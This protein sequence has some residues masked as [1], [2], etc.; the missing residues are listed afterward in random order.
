MYAVNMANLTDGSEIG[1]LV[2][3]PDAGFDRIAGLAGRLL[4]MPLA[5]LTVFDASYQR[6]IGR[7]GSLLT[8]NTI[9]QSFC[10]FLMLTPDQELV[11]HD[12]VQDPRCQHLSCVQA[13]TPIR[14]YAGVPIQANG[15]VVGTLCV[16]DFKS[17]PEFGLLEVG[18]LQDLALLA[19][20]E[21]SRHQMA[22]GAERALVVQTAASGQNQAIM[23]ALEDAI[24]VRG[25]DNVLAYMN[26]AAAELHSIG[27]LPDNL[28]TESQVTENRVEGRYE[29]SIWIGE[30]WRRL[31]IRVTPYIDGLGQLRGTIS[32]AREVGGLPEPGLPLSASVQIEQRVQERTQ[33]LARLAFT[34]ALTGLGNRR[35]M[36]MALEHHLAEFPQVPLY[37][38]LIDLNDFKAINDRFGH[39]RGDQ[40]LR[41]LGQV[42]STA[43][44]ELVYR[45][46]GDEFVILQPDRDG[47]SQTG[48]AADVLSTHRE[49]LRTL[50]ARIKSLPCTVTLPGTP[51]LSVSVGSASAPL[52]AR[53]ATDLLRLAD[54]RMLREKSRKHTSRRV[55]SLAG[56]HDA[57]PAPSSGLAWETMRSIF[58][59]LTREAEFTDEVY[60]TLLEAGLAAISGANAGSLYVQDADGFVLVAQ[61]GFTS[62]II[63]LRDSAPECR[64]WYGTD[65]DW[66]LARA[67]TLRGAQIA[68]RVQTVAAFG[69]DPQK[70][71]IYAVT[72]EP[73]KVSVCVPI[74][75][76]GLMMGLLNVESFLH[77][78]VFGSEELK[79]IEDFAAQLA[80][81]FTAHNRARRERDRRQEVEC[82]L[83]VSEALHEHLGVGGIHA[84]LTE[85]AHKLFGT[86]QVSLLKPDWQADSALQEGVAQQN[87]AR[88]QVAALAL[89][90]E[91]SDEALF[92]ADQTI[93]S[94]RAAQSNVPQTGP[95]HALLAV[96]LLSGDNGCLGVVLVARPVQARFSAR[97]ARLLM[98][99]VSV[100]VTALDRAEAEQALKGRADEFR[101]LSELTLTSIEASDPVQVGLES[102][103]LCASFFGADIGGYVDLASRRIHTL[104]GQ[105]VEIGAVTL[106]RLRVPATDWSREPVYGTRF[107]YD[108]SRHESPLA[109]FQ[110]AGLKTSLV[111]EIVVEGELRGLISIGWSRVLNELPAAGAAILAR[112]AELVSLATERQETLERMAGTREGALMA[113]GL[114][115]E[116]R[117]FETSGHT[118]RVVALADQLGRRLKLP[119]DELE[120]LRQGAYLHDIGKLAIPDSILLKP[121]KLDPQEWRIMQEHAATGADLGQRIPALRGRVLDI[122]RHHH[123]R[124]DGTGYP[125]RLKGD[126]IPQGARMFTLVD[127][128]DALTSDRPYK[129]AWSLEAALREIGEQAG[130]QFDPALTHEFLGLFV[131]ASGASTETEG[132]VKP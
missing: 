99:V 27:M 25:P 31:Q 13:E 51:P 32:V 88:Q 82:L 131:P 87:A 47:Q 17:R 19:L 7:Y 83:A 76:E 119:A 50:L 107:T 98:G 80:T 45:L 18:I 68:E 126:R 39:E 3:L 90:A 41:L 36:E 71:R 118:T 43:F 116:L 95:T 78:D 74:V 132:E 56:R 48:D 84:V 111:A 62:T 124:W 103:A 11:V 33:S 44:G 16:F 67:R 73:M 49:K 23:G 30:A 65:L 38:F 4:G 101:L 52:E 121:G 2:P 105:T 129:R 92:L 114:A 72:T 12:A 102:L 55:Q 100:A 115:L 109:A 85:Q 28:A 42:L 9:D 29:Q 26:P 22:L 130:K 54:E 40:A 79:T 6:F 77:E 69:T 21:V 24:F 122:I 128:F 53:S 120:D 86:L 35:A 60:G 37:L 91:A 70:E 20:N 66:T 61:V 104:N 75:S 93:R 64:A 59:L 106:Q 14:F 108:Y 125:G 113:L 15:Q 127:T 94:G 8:G 97:D 96:P 63:G 34:D 112:A 58:S 110:R 1:K 10:Q 123:E 89:G 81:I 46:G 117:D 5:F 57:L